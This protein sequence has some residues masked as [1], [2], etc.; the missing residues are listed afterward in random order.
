MLLP[1]PGLCGGPG[2]L[3]EPLRASWDLG[4]SCKIQA[5]S[6]C[7][8]CRRPEGPTL[9]EVSREGCLEEAAANG[10]QGKPGLET[11]EKVEGSGSQDR[12]AT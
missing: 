9:S 4:S 11:K 10:P 5:R 7:V 8:D 12:C 1:N 6:V 3:Q 2:K